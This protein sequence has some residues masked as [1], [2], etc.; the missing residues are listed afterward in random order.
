MYYADKYGC[1]SDMGFCLV[2]GKDFTVFSPLIG[3]FRLSSRVT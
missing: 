3:F 2:S 1:V